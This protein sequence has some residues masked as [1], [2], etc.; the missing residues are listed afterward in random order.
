VGQPFGSP[1]RIDEVS[2]PALG[3]GDPWLS[4]DGRR[5]Y[6]SRSGAGDSADWG[7]YYSER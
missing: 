5:L 3:E 4:A 2:D 1:A 6:F 7:V